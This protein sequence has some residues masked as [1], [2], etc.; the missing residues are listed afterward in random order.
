MEVP[1]DMPEFEVLSTLGRGAKST[2]FAVSERATG[3]LYAIKRVQRHEPEDERFL[4]QMEQEHEIACQFNHPGLRRSVR[5]I[6]KRRL[7]KTIEICLVMEMVDGTPLD[8]QRPEYLSQ[9]I[10]IAAYAADAL[11]WLHQQG[12]VHADI[13]PNNVLVTVDGHVKIID[14]GQSCPIGTVKTRIQGTP[15]YIAPEQVNRTAL[16]PQ[17][18]IFNLGATLYW[19]LT[20]KYVPTL[21]HRRTDTLGLLTQRELFPPH[22]LNPLVP[23]AL[24]K[25]ILD[26][27]EEDVRRRPADMM[28]LRQRL[29]LAA[30]LAPLPGSPE[31]R[32]LLMTSPMHRQSDA[33]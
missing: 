29:E 10:A 25:L 2:I 19:C 9:L 27:I 8:R 31:D 28:V 26:C 4:T 22:E 11:G 5:L 14:F 1:L 6:R 7:L 21:I 33:G 15:D 23:L 17:T 20:G 32:Y 24:S 13:K 3:Q 30:S 18:D 16:V 12:Y